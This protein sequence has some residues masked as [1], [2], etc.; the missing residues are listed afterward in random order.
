MGCGHNRADASG[1]AY[2]GGRMR[3]KSI[4]LVSLL[5]A[6]LLT[7]GLVPAAAQEATPVPPAAS[8]VGAT[9]VAP[10]DLAGVMPQPLAGERRAAFDAYLAGS[11][12]QFDVPGAAVAVVENG[13]VV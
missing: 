13:A 4:P 11:L 8:P 5:V 7:A 1:R 12:A 9:P 6:L 3:Q 2:G 10:V